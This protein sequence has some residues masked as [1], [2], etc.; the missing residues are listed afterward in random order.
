MGKEL[1]KKDLGEAVAGLENELRIVEEER[2]AAEAEETSSSIRAFAAEARLR[3]LRSSLRTTTAIRAR[4]E[5]LLQELDEAKNEL[6]EA[7]LRLELPP[8]ASGHDAMNDFI[9]GTDG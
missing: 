6:A 2:D 3:D 5:G 8:E 4:I 9:R 7:V 1:T